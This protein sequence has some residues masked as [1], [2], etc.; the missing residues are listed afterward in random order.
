MIKKNPHLCIYLLFCSL[1]LLPPAL[2]KNNPKL[3]NTYPSTGFTSPAQLK[4]RVLINGGGASFPYILYSKWF[5]EYHRLNPLIKI[6]YRSIGSSGGIRQFTAGVL[7][8]G[9]TDVPAK[10]EQLQK[11]SRQ[12]VHIP[13]T[14]GAVV[15]TYNVKSLKNQP[16]KLNASLLRE[17]YRGKVTSWNHDSVKKLNPGLNLPDQN[18]VPVY[19]ADGSGTTAVFT[20]FLAKDSTEWT[21]DLGY[22]KSIKWPIGIGGKGNEGVLGLIQKIEGTIGYVG[23]SYA[24]MRKQRMALMQNKGG[25]YVK[26]TL[27]N[28]RQAASEQLKG[29]GD[30]FSAL[31]SVKEQSSYPLS[32]YSYLLLHGSI[33]SE[34]ENQMFHFLHWALGPGQ[35]L[36]SDLGFSPLPKAVVKKVKVMLS[37][38]S[39]KPDLIK[40]KAE[41]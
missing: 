26:P 30:I 1:V 4:K 35:A 21:R 3:K 13:L 22:G 41:K 23:M 7:D 2:A 24:L 38:F 6:N 32:A 5:L 28:V 14:L 25:H 34:K 37:S 39:G 9:A 17:I 19:R 18:I 36:T 40:A 8:F 20:E 33:Q 12:V 15:V 10:K 29:T 11:S 27:K 31:V 16:L